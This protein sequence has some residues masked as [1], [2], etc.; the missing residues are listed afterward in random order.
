MKFKV[1]CLWMVFSPL[2]LTVFAE[3]TSNFGQLFVQVMGENN[4]PIEIS[5]VQLWVKTTEGGIGY[6]F[7]TIP[8]EKPGVYKIENIPTGEYYA[9][10][11]NKNGFAPFW[12]YKIQVSQE[13]QQIISCQLSKGGEIK[14]RVLNEMRYP[15]SD[16]P[17]TVNSLECRRD[18][19]TDKNGYF[20]ARH[21]SPTSYSI[22]VEPLADSVYETGVHKGLV[23][24]DSNN[25]T[26]ILKQKDIAIDG[27]NES[28]KQSKV[29]LNDRLASASL[30]SRKIAEES[31]LNKPAPPL[32]I[33]KW[34]PTTFWDL[35]L[36][37]KVVLV[38]FWGVWCSP[39]IKEI[40]FL[41]DIHNRYSSK[42]LVIIGV[43]TLDKKELVQE[44]MTKN[45]MSYLVGVDYEGKTAEL[46][47]V[48]GYPI[49]YIIDQLG[50]IRA[51]DPKK[52]EI[53]KLLISLLGSS[54]NMSSK[55]N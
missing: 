39:C 31:L 21:L 48:S 55:K 16:M 37:H 19:V 11:I 50:Y 17:V 2:C 5:F 40:P 53:E 25:I 27:P 22:I 15:I 34:Y 42:G 26:I 35:D 29:L 33:E 4:K 49:I 51:V 47:Y 20:V 12:K 45:S 28:A 41:Q 1:L 10:A 43:H 36:K 18:I 8:T 52:S 6:S 32:I 54:S 3:D 14:G 7:A 9:I 44:F 30:K 38:D 23:S 13:D 46:Y 24:C